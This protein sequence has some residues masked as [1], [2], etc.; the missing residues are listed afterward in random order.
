MQ[1]PEDSFIL[2]TAKNGR[3][4]CLWLVID[5]GEIEGRTRI[6]WIY[7]EVREGQTV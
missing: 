2:T 7:G 3:W 1:G 5:F 6:I 4:G